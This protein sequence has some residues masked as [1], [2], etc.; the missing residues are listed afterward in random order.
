M[1][2]TPQAR[3]NRLIVKKRKDSYQEEFKL[4]EPACC[5]ECGAVYIQ[6]RWTWKEASEGCQQVLCPSCRRCSDRYP[7]G[8]IQIT[9]NF[10]RRHAEEILSLVRNVETKEKTERP[11]ERIMEISDRPSSVEITTTGV[12]VARRI[13]EALQRAYKGEFRFNYADGEPHIRIQWYRDA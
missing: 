3:N 8:W 7:A 13:G 1:P 11:L 10:F 2:F 9:G 4:A 6:G 12:H 5:T